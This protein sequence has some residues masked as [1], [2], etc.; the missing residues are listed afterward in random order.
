MPPNHSNILLGIIIRRK[1]KSLSNDY[2]IIAV[3]GPSEC[4]TEEDYEDTKQDEEK[5]QANVKFLFDSAVSLS[6]SP[7]MLTKSHSHTQD[8][9]PDSN[10]LSPCTTTAADCSEE[11]IVDNIVSLCGTESCIS[12]RSSILADKC[13]SSRVNSPSLKPHPHQQSSTCCEEGM[14]MRVTIDPEQDKSCPCNRTTSTL[15][16]DERNTCNDAD[17]S[18]SKCCVHTSSVDSLETTIPILC[19]NM[20]VHTVDDE[21]V[22]ASHHNSLDMQHQKTGEHIIVTTQ[23]T[24]TLQGKDVVCV[25]SS[26]D[27]STDKNQKDDSVRLV[28]HNVS[29]SAIVVV[30]EWFLSCV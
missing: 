21:K 8:S 2:N 29:C 3:S 28:L 19:T 26:K 23:D 17:F 4:P 22:K 27:V 13:D 5:I 11:V 12:S 7:A 24:V 14:C 30:V 1:S 25:N 10:T 20:D 15:Q 18:E 16:P 9:V 6:N